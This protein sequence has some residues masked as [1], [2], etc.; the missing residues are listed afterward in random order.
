MAEK[1]IVFR[2][3]TLQFQGLFEI[4]GLF[5]SIVKWLD[6]HNY[7]LFENKNYEEIFE[8]DKKIV[9][10]LLP[11]KKIT[12]YYKFEIRIYLTCESL[13]E[14]E[15]ELNGVKYRLLKGNMT[16]TF[17]ATMITDYEN[18]WESRPQYFFFRTLMDKFIYRSHT[19]EYEH[20]LRTDVQQLEE[21]MKAYLNMFRYKI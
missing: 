18:R 4:K 2:D 6:E 17:D 1:K 3:K 12:D 13:K 9:F 11:Y 15:V 8:N 14:A 10:E 19:R 21:E 16:C 20:E 7:D 5:R